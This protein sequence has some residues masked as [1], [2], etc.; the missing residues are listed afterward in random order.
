MKDFL[1]FKKT[2]LS[3]I[4]SVPF[5]IVWKAALLLLKF[6]RFSTGGTNGIVERRS[7]ICGIKVMSSCE[8][9]ISLFSSNN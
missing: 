7:T 4:L 2:V 5:A 8:L 3:K 6:E 1:K 9:V